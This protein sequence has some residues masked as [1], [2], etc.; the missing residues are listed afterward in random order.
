[1]MWRLRTQNLSTPNTNRE[2]ASTA[3]IMEHDVCVLNAACM[4]YVEQVRCVQGFK[5]E[6]HLRWNTPRN[7]LGNAEYVLCLKTVFNFHFPLS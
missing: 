4:L 3:R 6:I 5:Q 2:T 1:M 7:T